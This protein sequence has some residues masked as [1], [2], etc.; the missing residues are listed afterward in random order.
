M[1]QRTSLTAEHHPLG[2]G[3]PY[4]LGDLVGHDVL[5]PAVDLEEEGVLCGGLVVKRLGVGLPV[6]R[7]D[8]E[9]LAVAEHDDP[10]R[11]LFL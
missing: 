4:G 9:L 10:E 11:A 3:P 2:D 7:L 6:E 1:R 5:P 8:D